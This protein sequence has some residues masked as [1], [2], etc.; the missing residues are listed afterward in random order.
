VWA[1][2]LG[3][4][5]GPFVGEL[6]D[7]AWPWLS[8]AM[9]DDEVVECPA[10]GGGRGGA[11]CKVFCLEIV[12]MEKKH[13]PHVIKMFYVYSKSARALHRKNKFSNAMANIFSF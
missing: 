2:F 5:R 13:A 6:D 8:D 12:N 7:G 1:V 10:G 3:S 4:E 9:T 11:D